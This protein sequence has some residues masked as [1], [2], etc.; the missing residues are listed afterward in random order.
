MRRRHLFPLLLLPVL[1]TRARADDDDDDHDRA[2]AAMERGEIRPL[3]QLLA[4]LER[5]FVG[6]VVDTDLDRDDGRWIYEFK[7]LPPSGRM[8]RV[9]IDAATG[10]VLR[11][12]GPVQERR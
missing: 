7:L 10:Q 3:S 5:R 1:A 11:T 8:Y 12:R 4:D 2:R 6:Q 9:K